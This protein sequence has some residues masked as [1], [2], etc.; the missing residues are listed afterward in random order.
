MLARE[1][2]DGRFMLIDGH[3]R[4]DVTPKAIVPVLV[5]D[6]D[7]AEVDKL[8]L[9]LESLSK[10]VGRSHRV[11]EHEGKQHQPPA[12]NRVPLGFGTTLS[13]KPK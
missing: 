5:V 9:T 4:A 2:L 3:L 1:L 13:R 7:E 8:L 10:Q 11:P 12:P 6:L